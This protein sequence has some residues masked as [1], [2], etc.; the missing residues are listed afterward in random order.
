MKLRNS[1]GTPSVLL[2]I[3]GYGIDGLTVQPLLVY[4][5]DAAH[6]RR[7]ARGERER[8]DVGLQTAASSGQLL[9][10]GVVVH[11]P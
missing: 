5:V 4:V 10:E 8:R 1:G 11:G 7:N 9:L 2:D 3:A 6:A